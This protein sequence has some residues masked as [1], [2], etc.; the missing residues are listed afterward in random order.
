MIVAAIGAAAVGQIRDGGL[1]VVIFASSGALE[2]VATQ[3]T[4][5]SVSAL[6]SLAPDHAIRARPDG[7]EEVVETADVQVGDV[8][9]V[10]PG[11]SIGADGCVIS[12]AS[13]VDQAS[14]TG[15]ALP[16]F[17]TIGDEV[18]AGTLN[19]QG[20]LLV[21]VTRSARD[22]VVSKIV[23]L[24]EEAI[25]TKARTQLFID[26]VERR[27]SVSMVVATV[28]VFAIPLALGGDLRATLLR[29]MTFMIVASPC[30][31]VLATMPPLL[32]AI[33]NASRHGVLVK[34]AVV[35][36]Q[37]ADVDRVAFDKT[38]TLTQGTP[39]V[40]RVHVL[41]AWSDRLDEGQLLAFTAGAERASE[42]PLGR[43]VVA[44]A[45]A[46]SICVAE[47]SDFRSTSGQSVY[48]MVDGTRVEVGRPRLLAGRYDQLTGQALAAVAELEQSGQTAVVVFLDGVAAGV[49][50]L[51]DQIRPGAAS[52]VAAL[53]EV[54][55]AES[56][57][58]TGDN[59]RAARQIAGEV[60]IAEIRAELLPEAKVIEVN[61]LRE[62]GHRVLVVGDGIND[63]PALAAADVGVAM[64]RNGSDLALSTADAVLVG[65][66]LMTLPAAI[67]LSRRA[68]RVIVQN[69][70]LAGAAIAGLVAWDLLGHLPLPLGVAGHEGG[71]VLVGLNGLRLLRERAWRMPTPP[72]GSAGDKRQRN[73]R[74]PVDGRTGALLQ[75]TLRKP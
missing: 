52:A 44:A 66:E 67:E 46:R 53:S 62:A 31:V 57:L 48:A 25:A 54:T 29:A 73:V 38:G 19:G 60:G 34:S 50:G 51:A 63:A 35:M 5:D 11:E 30:A 1:L 10:R 28:A 27:Y 6:L 15:E 40:T 8:L 2:A 23:A 3:R 14:I 49:I 72:P 75:P 37:L 20:A 33:A 41:P 65:D 64:G 58:L 42:H 9:V 71:T 24:V 45:V 26:K 7:I 17:R 4:R 12:G 61:R 21:R 22:S 55:G 70:V 13:E 43:A 59:L 36:E 56:L 16:V 18:F 32:S 74:P 68:R 69:L 47:T 39:R